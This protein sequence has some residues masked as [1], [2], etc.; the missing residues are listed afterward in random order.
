MVEELNLPDHSI[1]QL[2]ERV[3]HTDDDSFWLPEKFIR[4]GQTPETKD[5]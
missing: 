2:N 1:Y 5:S 4:T 3:R